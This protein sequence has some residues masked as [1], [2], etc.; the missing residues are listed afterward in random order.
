MCGIWG[1]ISKLAKTANYMQ[2]YELFKRIK[3]RGPDR[4]NFLEI[5]EFVDVFLGFHRLSIMDTSANGDQPFI[6]GDELCTTYCVCNGEIY[7]HK[8]LINKYNL[9]P[10]SSSDCEVIPLIY[11][12]YGMSQLMND[13]IG[14]FA[15]V[16]M[17]IYPL[18]KK[19][20][21]YC[22]RDPIGVRPL[23][24]GEDVNGFAFSSELKGLTGIIDSATIV[25]FSPGCYMNVTL[26]GNG[27]TI[28]CNHEMIPYYE[29]D[30]KICT[31][32]GNIFDVEY[33]ET[34]RSN[35]RSILQNCVI[36]RLQ[37]D[38]PL[39]ALLSGGL[40]SSLVVAIASRYLAKY[41]KKLRTFSIGMLGG[42]DE[43]YAKIVAEHCNTIHTHI[44]LKEQDF[45]N[46]IEKVI[47]ATETYDITT[48]RASVG[49]YLISQFIG[50]QTDIKVLL[51]GD[52]SDE[53]CA[54]YKYNF[55]APSPA[56]SHF[57]CS[58]LLREMYL[59]DILRADRGIASA[60]LEA[61]VPYLDYRFV[62]YY[63]SIDPRLRVPIARID[64]GKLCE[65]WLL[66]TSF[67]GTNYLPNTVLWRPKEAFSDGVS[68][69]KKS[70]YLII[71]NMVDKLYS[72]DDYHRMKETYTHN[73]PTSKE[74]LYYRII[75]EK[76]FGN[77]SHV[78]P[79]MWLPQWCDTLEPSARILSVYE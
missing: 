20:T 43:Q 79:H 78:I 29:K 11:K 48:I 60:G 36:T 12:R 30:Y 6:V 59:Y 32:E 21:I 53:I 76:M 28:T 69:K 23:F 26:D 13:L 42:T 71:Q 24:Y 27:D 1:Y 16:I 49:Q 40:D 39:G 54:G 18:N 65:K 38:R 33:L 35:I 77:I 74:S 61:R 57:D 25:P 68:Q 8:E 3:H 9:Q 47:W 17:D 31:F 52:G 63:M 19:I 75:F 22:S 41:G 7:N 37:S 14:E 46:A 56:A 55:L 44:E 45:L 66:R 64:G 4:S 62:D 2:L 58:R 50:C 67:Q 15:F 70:W 10:K 72:D 5:N 34:I 73:P 51:L